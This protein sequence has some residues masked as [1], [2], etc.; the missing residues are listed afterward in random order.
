MGS[1][2]NKNDNFVDIFN[3]ILNKNRQIWMAITNLND[4]I[5]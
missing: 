1:I 3:K 5:P 2:C 4:L